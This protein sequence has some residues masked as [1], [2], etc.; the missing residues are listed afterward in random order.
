MVY[1]NSYSGADLGQMA[2]DV[3]GGLLSAI[4]RQI[5]VLGTLLVVGIV[6]VLITDLL[7]G[8]F[9]IFKFLGFRK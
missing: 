5:G 4:V 9:G 8:V 7:T 3:A 1:Y 2:I 6:L